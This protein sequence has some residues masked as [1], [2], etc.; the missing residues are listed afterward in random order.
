MQYINDG[1]P[2]I[3]WTL[4]GLFVIGLAITLWRLIVIFLAM[5]NTKSLYNK[6]YAALQEGEKGIEKA[7]EICSRTPGPVATIVHAGLSR[8]NRG[9]DHVEKAVESAGSVEMAFLENGLVWLATI[10]NIAPMIG[11]F[12]TIVGMIKAFKDIAAQ[13]DVEPS[14]VA[15]GISIALITTAGGLLVAIPI[16]LAYNLC[17]YLIDRV[18]VSM[19]E[20]ASRFIDTLVDL[21]YDKTSS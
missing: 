16:Q 2:P 7:S 17:V 3:M 21:G 19:E 14:I 1:G 12:G 15:T 13:G 5:I 10:A 11:F 20:N 4:V 6:V 8:V 18:V 9:I